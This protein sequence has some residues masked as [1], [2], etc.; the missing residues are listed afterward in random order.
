MKKMIACFAILASIC[1]AG[2]ITGCAGGS[3]IAPT[4]KATVP[5]P[6]YDR[7]GQPVAVTPPAPISQIDAI[8]VYP[9]EGTG[10]VHRGGPGGGSLYCQY[11]ESSNTW[12]IGQG[13]YQFFV[14]PAVTVRKRGG[15]T[16]IDAQF[17]FAYG[18]GSQMAVSKVGTQHIV[19][20]SQPGIYTAVALFQTDKWYWNKATVKV[21]SDSELAQV[22]VLTLQLKSHVEGNAANNYRETNVLLTQYDTN[23]LLVA[24]T[25]M[26]LIAAIRVDSARGRGGEIPSSLWDEAFIDGRTMVDMRS[27]P[28][29]QFTGGYTSEG[30]GNPF[31]FSNAGKYC[32]VVQLLKGGKIIATLTEYLAIADGGGKG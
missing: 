9:L 21:L 17:T 2:L 25:S 14:E 20:F 13:S 30:V 11:D 15:P 18:N 6:V 4:A 1:F 29:F 22:P 3:N 7:N 32:V 10:R 23:G 8:T 26:A 27:T 31:F 24:D 12:T 28:A 19:D 5:V 16:S